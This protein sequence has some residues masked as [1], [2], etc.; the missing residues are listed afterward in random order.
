M[1]LRIRTN[2]A[3]LIA[4]RNMENTSKAHG[5]SLEKLSSGYRINRAADDAAGLAISEGLRAK[6]RSL[7]V[8][9]RNANDGVSMVQVAEGGM[10]EITNTL[11][12][13]RELAMQSASD[14]ISNPQ[15]SFINREYTEL[16]YE[17]ERISNS[18][19]YNSLRLLKGPEGNNDVE[20]LTVHVGAGDGSVTNVD[21]MDFSLEELRLNTWEDLELG[22][23]AEIG[24]RSLDEDF[25][26]TTATA[27]LTLLDT[28]LDKVADKRA[29][30]GAKQSRLNSAINNL[31]I[32]MENLASANSRIRDVDFA[33]ETA[34][35][36]QVNI[37]RQA[38][39]SV[40]SQAN[41]APEL[42]LAL[43]R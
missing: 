11:I 42:A 38:G 20:F 16:V 27:K 18:S 28:A 1:G 25:T 24:P 4:Q 26:R 33:S 8:A 12:R 13:V 3:S 17:I 40:L 6:V 39:A 9:K 41:S 34:R 19:E 22:V 35:M 30:L 29:T 43:L 15:R 5:E 14:T 23:E 10:S 31:G 32:Q 36:T 7:E 2:T 21:T 37:L